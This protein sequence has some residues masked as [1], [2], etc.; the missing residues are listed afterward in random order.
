MC[1]GDADTVVNHRWGQSSAEFLQKL[2]LSVEFKTFPMMGHSACPEELR[3]LSLFLS[4]V[5]GS[6]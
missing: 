4:K 3:D 5:I 6:K 2:G 1:H